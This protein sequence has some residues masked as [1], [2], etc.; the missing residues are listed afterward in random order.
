MTARSTSRGFRTRARWL[1]AMALAIVVSVGGATVVAAV[2]DSGRV[3]EEVTAGAQ[4]TT[5]QAHGEVAEAA[6]GNHGE[7][8]NVT[9]MMMMLALQ[10]GVIILAAKFFGEI[11]ERYLK[12]PSVLGELA[13]GIVIGPFALGGILTVPG[14]GGVMF[15]V[16][17]GAIPVS[18]ELWAFAQVAA[19]I[20][21]FMAGLETDL[22]SFLKYALPASIIAIGGVVFPFVFGVWATV[23]FGFADSYM[24]GS[25]LFMGTI[26][27]ATS[28]GITARVLSDIRRLDTPEGVTILGA[29]VVDD[30]I[31]IMVLAV[32]IGLARTGV[33]D[34]GNAGITF[35]KAG[36][37][38]LGF[39][40]IGLAVAS[41]I[42]RFLDWFK[43]RGATIA[44]SLSLAFLAAA[45][46][47]MFGLAMIIG[48]YAMGLELS[49]TKL[50]HYLE[51]NLEGVYHALVPIFFC[52][53]GMLVDFEAMSTAV[54]FGLVVS[55]LAII[56]KVAGCGVPALAVGFNRRGAWRIG[57]G[58]LPRGE[59]ALIIA[60]VGLAEGI[61]G[62]AIFGVSIMMTIITTLLAPIFLVPAF[63]TGGSGLRDDDGAAPAAE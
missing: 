53:L 8:H 43:G 29:A 36:G 44:V 32:V 2:T 50:S 38:Y 13:A 45:V 17:P 26:M 52:V 25:A 22:Q 20:L 16:N 28:V 59:V 5:E 1:A 46:A 24:N 6:D 60:G 49:D 55:V 57:L 10:L 37:F 34:W 35:L 11:T 41:R 14:I 61:I 18:N 9:H 42:A 47:E 21:L 62:P 19:I 48:A 33:F 15:P 3:A 12:Q 31:G 58:M 4:E 40:V 30:V 51:E 27:V 56:S 23:W 63:Q 39:M 7:E 54:V